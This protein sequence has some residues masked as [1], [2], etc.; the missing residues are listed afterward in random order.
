MIMHSIL[1]IRSTSL[2]PFCVQFVIL[3]LLLF[4]T[5][6]DSS[7][8][9]PL[10]KAFKK[11]EAW[12]GLSWLPFSNFPHNFPHLYGAHINTHK[13][14]EDSSKPLHI[15][16]PIEGILERKDHPYYSYVKRFYP[17]SPIATHLVGSM[18]PSK[19]AEE[20]AKVH[21]FIHDRHYNGIEKFRPKTDDLTLQSNHFFS[22]DYLN[23]NFPTP[24]ELAKYFASD[25]P[26][27]LSGGSHLMSSSSGFASSSSPAS[28]SSMSFGGN[29]GSPFDYAFERI[30]DMTALFIAVNPLPVYVPIQEE[31]NANTNAHLEATSIDSIS[32]QPTLDTLS[33]DSTTTESSSTPQSRESSQVTS[34][35]ELSSPSSSPSS[36]EE[37]TEM[38]SVRPVGLPSFSSFLPHPF[39]H[40]FRK[41]SHS[42]TPS[43][44][45]SLS[46]SSSTTESNGDDSVSDAE[47][48]RR[49]SIE[50][51]PRNLRPT[52]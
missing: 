10:G 22:H 2:S 43:P 17:Q 11:L 23:D 44:T 9:K 16:L 25:G 26:F 37:L 13:W 4:L 28:R 51:R 38:S 31:D 41:S 3:N 15:G 7:T 40:T 46:S 35:P 48:D 8:C 49:H 19:V 36:K 47:L 1:P 24:N 34:Q 6:I 20:E 18:I 42:I 12:W 21:R 50:E 30:P 52:K 5:T 32:N 27:P 29:R 33:A 45:S 39:F 14:R